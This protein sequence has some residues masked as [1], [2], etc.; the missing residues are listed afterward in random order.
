MEQS[1][2]TPPEQQDQHSA[3][4]EASCP[5]C[6]EPAEKDQLVGLRCGGRIALDYRRPPG[7][8]LPTAIVAGVALVAAVAFG[9]GLREIT[10][11]ARTEVADSAPASKAVQRDLERQAEQRRAAE[12]RTAERRRAAAA[13]KRR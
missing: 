9:W 6:G 11:N 1:T 4:A 5:H 10:D 13:R 7:W 12:A 2:A 8:K 3:S